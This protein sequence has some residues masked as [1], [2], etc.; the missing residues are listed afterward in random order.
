[1][2]HEAKPSVT[3]ELD[4]DASKFTGV[5]ITVEPAGGSPAPT[6]DPIALIEFS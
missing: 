6:S 3:M 1:M 4:G 5:G 2:P